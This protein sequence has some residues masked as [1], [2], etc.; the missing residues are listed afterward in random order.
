MF[1]LRLRIDEQT[2]VARENIWFRQ[3]ETRF[4]ILMILIQLS[5]Y[6]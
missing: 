3:R 1:V 4:N 2:W 5:W 6:F